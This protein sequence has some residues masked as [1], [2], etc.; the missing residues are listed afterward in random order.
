M[1]AIGVVVVIAIIGSVVAFTRRKKPQTQ[2]KAPKAVTVQEKPQPQP[3]V[4]PAKPP[5]PETPPEEVALSTGYNDL[6]ALLVGGLPEGF[7]ILLLSPPCD[8]RDLLLRKIISSAISSQLPTFFVSNDPNR[9]QD[10]VGRYWKDF[11]AL[12]PQADK[13]LSPPA[14]LYK[15]AGFDNLSDF[16]ISLTK[17]IEGRVKQKA[18][19]K[20]MIVD[21]LTDILL[22][23]KALTSRKW[24]S[25]FITKRKGEGFTVLAFLNPLV[26]AKEETQTLIDVFDGVIEIYERELRERARRFLVVKRMYGRKYS[27]SELMLDKDKLF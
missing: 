18:T 26:S 2:P 13:V 14:N 19:G 3:E 8:E 22:Q 10:L 17:T 20:L 1:G 24:L 11:Y 4:A 21:L 23:H 27:D 16:N 5:P 9:I 7:A 25:D 6:D 12:S 15:I